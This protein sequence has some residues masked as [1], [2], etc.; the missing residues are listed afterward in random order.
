MKDQSVSAL[1]C[2][3]SRLPRKYR[4]TVTL[5]ELKEMSL[6]DTAETLG[7]TPAAIKTRQFRARLLLAERLR[8]P[9]ANRGPEGQAIQSRCGARID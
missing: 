7:T 5:R 9:L 2:A 6:K 3:V 8:D 1:R 4:E